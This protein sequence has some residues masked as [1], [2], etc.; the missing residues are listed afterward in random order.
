M[1]LRN[2]MEHSKS[3]GKHVCHFACL[4]TGAGNWHLSKGCPFSANC[5]LWKQSH[6]NVTEINQAL[7]QQCQ[8]WHLVLWHQ[9]P[10]QQIWNYPFAGRSCSLLL[11]KSDVIP[12]ISGNGFHCTTPQCWD[13]YTSAKFKESYELRS[14]VFAFPPSSISFDL[15]LVTFI[16]PTMGMNWNLCL[17]ASIK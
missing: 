15:V 4:H 13:W 1:G 16:Y 5:Y 10:W 17:K 9:K 2:V 6:Q 14:R 12:S 8:M 7:G 3:Y 11:M